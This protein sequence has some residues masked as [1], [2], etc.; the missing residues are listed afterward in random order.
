MSSGW[1]AVVDEI[2]AEVL[3]HGATDA[4]FASAH[5]QRLLTKRIGA[6]PGDRPEDETALRQRLDRA[7]AAALTA[8]PAEAP[9]ATPT[10]APRPRAP[11]PDHAAIERI[12]ADVFHTTTDG[13]A[14]HWRVLRAKALKRV[15]DRM[16]ADGAGMVARWRAHRIAAR[17]AAAMR[18]DFTR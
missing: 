6:Q 5:G 14:A 8:L 1:Q 18:R 12:A 17:V 10:P 15:D 2:C 11:L 3:R 13:S 16:R 9:A 7:I 4:E